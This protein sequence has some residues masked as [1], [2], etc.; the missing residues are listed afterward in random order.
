MKVTPSAS[1]LWVKRLYHNIVSE[2]KRRNSESLTAKA[3]RARRA[4]W[5]EKPEALIAFLESHE[6]R[7]PKHLKETG[8]L[9]DFALRDFVALCAF[10]IQRSMVRS[11]PVSE[12]RIDPW[13]VSVMSLS[14]RSMQS[15]VAVTAGLAF[16]LALVAVQALRAWRYFPMFM[17]DQ[18]WYLQVAGRV[19]RGDVL[20]RDVA[21][22]YGPLPAQFLA[23]LLRWR[24]EAGLATTVNGVLAAVSL[25]LTY[26]ALRGLRLHALEQPGAGCLLYTSPSPRD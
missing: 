19:S 23:V 8:W 1:A 2:L 5:S 11:P 22:A 14:T 6:A 21:W 15:R 10:V 25:L 17:G 9:R 4:E 13:V 16:L 20:Y 26:A 3:P 18:G 24:P 7:S 12:F